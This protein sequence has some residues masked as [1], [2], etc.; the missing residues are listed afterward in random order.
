MNRKEFLST[1]GLGAAAIACSYCFGGCESNDQVVTPPVVDFTLDL[2]DPANAALKTNGGSLYKEG[3]IVARTSAGDY[4]AVSATCTHAAGTV[5][6]V[7]SGNRFHCP[8]HGSDFGPTGAVIDGPA[9]Q[10]LEAYHISLNSTSLR[11]YT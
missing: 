5:Q 4:I 8:N 11:V 7:A 3:V 6:Y 2:N 10:A 9:L 1:L